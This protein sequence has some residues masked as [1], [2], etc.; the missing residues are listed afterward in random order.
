[1]NKLVLL[2]IA[3]RAYDTLTGALAELK[4]LR[5][6]VIPNARSAAETILSGYSQGRF[7]LLELLDVRGSLLQALLREQEALQN[8]HI[9]VATIE[10]L[11]GNPFSLTRES[12]R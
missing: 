2:S 6:S 3:G 9:A 8:F 11:V 10:G 5:S 7:T 1:I 12:S 4:L